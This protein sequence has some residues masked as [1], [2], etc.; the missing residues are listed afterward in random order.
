V[1]EITQHEINSRL[2]ITLSYSNTLHSFSLEVTHIREVTAL[3]GMD[4]ISYLQCSQASWYVR[5]LY[6]TFRE[7]SVNKEKTKP[8]SPW[9]HALRFK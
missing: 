1:W 2:H 5:H 6:A 9:G 4:F 3:L 7:S 8:Y